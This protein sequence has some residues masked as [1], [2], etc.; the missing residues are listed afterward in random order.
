MISTCSSSAESA[1]LE[2]SRVVWTRF[3][4][5]T[6]RNRCQVVF[7]GKLSCRCI[8]TLY[9]GRWPPLI[10]KGDPLRLSFFRKRL[11]LFCRCLWLR[12]FLKRKTHRERGVSSS[13]QLLELLLFEL[14]G[15]LT[16]TQCESQ[17]RVL[18][19][20]RRL[21]WSWR[22]TGDLLVHIESRWHRRTQRSILTLFV[23]LSPNCFRCPSFNFLIQFHLS[24][25]L[26]IVNQ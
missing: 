11:G 2:V 10:V 25:C 7:S 12:Y 22:C 18:V 3:P 17:V 4:S 15:F 16:L 5:L 21:R 24:L 1:L 19:R 13:G 23:L 26:A 8:L 14:V 6:T 20:R 9:L